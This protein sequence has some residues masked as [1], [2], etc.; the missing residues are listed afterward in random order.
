MN[1]HVIKIDCDLQ[2]TSLLR[3]I[4]SPFAAPVFNCSKFAASTRQHTH[5]SLNMHVLHAAIS[6]I[7]VNVLLAIRVNYNNLGKSTDR[8]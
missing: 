8:I 6:T 4:S 3:R 2:D 1:T 5:T 7:K